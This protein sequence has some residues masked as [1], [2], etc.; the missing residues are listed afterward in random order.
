MFL[1][2]TICGN[3]CVIGYEVQRG[4][5]Q[6]LD[7]LYGV[8]SEGSSLLHLAIDSGVLKVN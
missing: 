6:K 5:K 4:T 8:D 2:S 3:F 1:F 7:L